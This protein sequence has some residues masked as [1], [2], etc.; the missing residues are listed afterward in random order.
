[1]MKMTKFLTIASGLL[2]VVD[3]SI[4]RY[5]LVEIDTTDI[6]PVPGPEYG[7]LGPIFDD[8]AVDERTLGGTLYRS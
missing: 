6:A 2:I 1:M 3:S 4:T 8:V 5:L 7:E